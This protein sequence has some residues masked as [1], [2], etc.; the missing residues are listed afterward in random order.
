MRR[1]NTE[2]DSGSAGIGAMI[3]F[4]ALILVS[5]VVSIV[6]I[7]FGQELFEDSSNDA[8]K[9]DDL[10]FGK[11]LITNA[12]VTSIEL[13]SDGNP[14]YMNLLLTLELTPGSPNIADDLVQWSVLCPNEEN[15]SRFRWSN[16]GNLEAATTSTG[17]GGDIGAIDE[18]EVGINYM[19]AISLYHTTDD[20]GDGVGDK[21]GC[22]PNFLE[23][24]TL[25]FVMPSSGSYSSWDLRYDD[26]HLEA[27]DLLI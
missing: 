25:V 18:L 7:S 13:D 8:N 12:V 14:T 17:D 1:L 2:E 21:G 10:M 26:E 4:V 24:H 20:D 15:P 22:P 11:I 27:G 23:T 3:I 16:D 9:N 5:A 6:L 19:L